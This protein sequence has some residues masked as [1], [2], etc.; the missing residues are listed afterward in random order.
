MEEKLKQEEAEKRKNEKEQRSLSVSSTG[1]TK[2]FSESMSPAELAEW[3]LEDLGSE[4]ADDIDKL[5]SI[6]IDVADSYQYYNIV[7]YIQDIKSMEVCFFNFQMRQ[8][9]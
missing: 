3:L 6:Y 7:D 2:T 4:F 8:K 5:K 9:L 1:K